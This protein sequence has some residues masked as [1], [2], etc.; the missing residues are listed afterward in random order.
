VPHIWGDALGTVGLLL[1]QEKG[2]PEPGEKKS[3]GM[4]PGTD[5]YIANYEPYMPLQQ[6]E[7]LTGQLSRE[8]MPCKRDQLEEYVAVGSHSQQVPQALSLTLEL[9]GLAVASDAPGLQR[10]PL[11]AGCLSSR[12]PE[13]AKA[14]SG[15]MAARQM[16]ATSPTRVVGRIVAQ[17][18]PRAVDPYGPLPRA[19]D[20]RTGAPPRVEALNIYTENVNSGPPSPRNAYDQLFG[21]D[22]EPFCEEGVMT[23]SR[24]KPNALGK[25][26]GYAARG[27]DKR[28]VSDKD[29][30]RYG[31]GRQMK[32]AR[33]QNLS[34]KKR[35]NELLKLP[36]MRIEPGQQHPSKYYGLI[37]T[38]NL[39]VV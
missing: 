4:S 35:L 21:E 38:Q 18:T 19:L 32:P 11:Q 8:V 20:P 6:W 10:L 37:P 9:P 39:R 22:S 31:N 23:V 30:A 12:S 2:K 34:S 27:P 24:V 13:A 7:A 26:T 25:N 16:N 5:H 29:R 3:P 15:S 14:A 33:Q 1:N 36:A 28:R 17:Q